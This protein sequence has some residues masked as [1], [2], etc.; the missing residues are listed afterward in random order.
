MEKAE[1]RGVRGDSQCKGN[2]GHGSERGSL[3][4]ED[5]KGVAEFTHVVSEPHSSM[6][7]RTVYFGGNPCLYCRCREPLNC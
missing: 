6:W 1:N 4:Q 2:D 5:S 3:E 7:T